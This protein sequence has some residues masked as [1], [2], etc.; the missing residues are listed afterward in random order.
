[1]TELNDM[2]LLREFAGRASE[3]AFTELVRRNVN[4]V[5]SVAFRYL[6]QSQDAQ[7]VTQ[8]V[9]ILLAQKAGR[10]GERTILTGWL[11]ET[12]R[13]TAMR[14][15]RTKR[16]RQWGE[17]ESQALEPEAHSESL[18]QRLEPLLEEG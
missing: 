12:T 6:G 9:F 4:L 16:R 18:W 2:D 5:Y 17:Q 13:F 7:D 1:M 15:M 10:L 11:Y 3:A 8:A 14:F